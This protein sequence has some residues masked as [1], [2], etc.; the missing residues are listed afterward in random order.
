V[1]FKM[2]KLNVHTKKAGAQSQ[3]YRIGF[4]NLYHIPNKDYN[5]EK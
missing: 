1:K 5:T 3:F 2:V 4:Y